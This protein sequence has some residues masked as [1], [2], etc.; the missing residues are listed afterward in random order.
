MHLLSRFYLKK[1]LYWFSNLVVHKL[2]EIALLRFKIQ[3][4]LIKTN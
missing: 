2:F 4:S 3:T 1:V